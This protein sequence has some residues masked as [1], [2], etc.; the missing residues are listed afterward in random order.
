MRIILT[1]ISL[2]FLLNNTVFAD[3]IYV[4]NTFSNTV[5]SVSGV[6][7]QPLQNI[8]TGLNPQEI[9]VSP[10]GNTLY[11]INATSS[12]ITV[13]DPLSQ[14]VKDRISLSCSPSAIAINPKSKDALLVCRSTNQLVLLNLEL[15]SQ[16]AVI[17]VPFAHSVAIH[18]FGRYAYVSRSM[19]SS[20]VDVIS[21][22]SKSKIGTISTGRSP[23]GLVVSLDGTKLYVVNSGSGSVSVVNTATNLVKST[24]SVG[25]NPRNAV[26]SPDG[27]K[28]YVSNYG[29]GSVSVIDT[30][31]SSV[32][33]TI[34]VGVN[35][36]GI[37]LDSKGKQLYV[38]NFSSN[39]LSVIDTA[40]LQTIATIPT[41]IGPMGIGLAIIDRTLPTTV[42]SLSGRKGL[43]DSY[44]SPVTVSLS[45]SDE[46]TGIK[47]LRYSLDNA[48]EVVM[49][50]HVVNTV[51]AVDGNHTIR[52]YAVDNTGSTE[53][54]KT[55]SFRIERP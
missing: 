22:A 45:A 30:S 28:L 9:A 5:T 11:V 10:Q 18:P 7:I 3:E 14:T 4:A 55:I 46:G 37:A 43:N 16:T 15:Q 51:I 49:T 2:G 41:G 36:H 24:I 52:Y 1:I 44:I 42:A 33:N 48:A 50:G 19:L 54:A 20:H 27:S 23:Q 13:I 34:E 26:I 17:P 53:E 21:L 47:E 39:T 25:S 40:T 29:S 31:T 12:E 6:T 32:S 35:P 8:P 38:S